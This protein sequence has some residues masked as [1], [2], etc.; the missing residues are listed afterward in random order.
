MKNTHYLIAYIL[1]TNSMSI[2]TTYAAASTQNTAPNA[3]QTGQENNN[4]RWRRGHGQPSTAGQ[5][6]AQQYPQ[7]D[8]WRN[9]QENQAY[10]QPQGNGPHHAQESNEGGQQ[11]GKRVS[12]GKGRSKTNKPQTPSRQLGSIISSL[13]KIKKELIQYE[14]AQ[15]TSK[16]QKPKGSSTH[17]RNKAQKPAP[18]LLPIPQRIDAAIKQLKELKETIKSQAPQAMTA[19]PQ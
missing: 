11:H 2:S 16:K 6:A 7:A 14:P 15:P 19:L 4:N 9:Y 12:R 3:Y 17:K 18:Q 1:L 5:P 8:Q 13:G 10:G